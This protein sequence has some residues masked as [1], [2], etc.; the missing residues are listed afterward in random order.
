MPEQL[1][2]NIWM[3]AK[4]EKRDKNWW[5]KEGKGIKKKKATELFYRFFKKRAS[6]GA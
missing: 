6:D 5:V 3:T 4:P 1:L 2:M